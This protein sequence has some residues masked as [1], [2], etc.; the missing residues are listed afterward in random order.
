MRIA[1]SVR[2]IAIAIAC[3]VA[4]LGVARAQH[5]HGHDH[6]MP[7]SQPVDDRREFVKF[8]APLVE[9][10]LANMRDHLHALQEIQDHL[11]QGH[12]DVAARIAEARLGMSSL[13]L[14]GAQNVAPYM[15]QG[16]QDAGTA[17]HKAASRFAVAATNAGVSGDYKAAFAGLAQ[18]TATCVACHAGYRIK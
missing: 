1:P 10:T 16:M 18:V 8:P 15:P 4:G 5:Q 3:A 9:H 7:A 6:S 14:H 2:S 11:G 12:F 13:G 17:M